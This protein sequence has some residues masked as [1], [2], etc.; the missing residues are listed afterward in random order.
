M[1]NAPI[2]LE[3]TTL[4]VLPDDFTDLFRVAECL[5]LPASSLRPDAASLPPGQL[6]STSCSW[7]PARRQ[8]SWPPGPTYILKG[9]E[10]AARDQATQGHGQAQS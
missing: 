8:S 6:V 1:L 7:S 10:V 4:R 2:I 9:S 3:E 5:I